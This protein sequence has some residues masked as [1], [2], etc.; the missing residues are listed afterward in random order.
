MTFA[1]GID[2]LEFDLE[3]CEIP[4]K[5]ENIY[6]RCE[7]TCWRCENTCK[8]CENICKRCEVPRR[9]EI[10]GVELDV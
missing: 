5:Y 2:F 9:C 3:R 1:P 4:R 6:W 7:N 10:P 8:R